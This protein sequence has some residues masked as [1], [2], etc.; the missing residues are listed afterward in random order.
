[1]VF[2]GD[3]LAGIQIKMYPPPRLNGWL[4]NID[5][6]VRNSYFEFWIFSEEGGV[7]GYVVCEWVC[8][9]HFTVFDGTLKYYEFRCVADAG[10]ES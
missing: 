1:V 6:C 2:G 3:L 8:S 5:V 9:V 7:F 10:A 4:T